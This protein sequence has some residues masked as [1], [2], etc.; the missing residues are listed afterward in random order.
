MT[1]GLLRP[2]WSRAR[3]TVGNKVAIHKSLASQAIDN[4]LPTR[5]PMCPVKVTGRKCRL[6]YCRLDFKRRDILVKHIARQKSSVKLQVS[7]AESMTFT[8]RVKDDREAFLDDSK[9]RKWFHEY[10][11]R[12]SDLPTSDWLHKKYIPMAAEKKT[13]DIKLAVKNKP[14]AILCDE[15]T[16]KEE[17]YFD[18]GCPKQRE[19]INYLMSDGDTGVLS[20][21]GGLGGGELQAGAGQDKTTT[22][23]SR[24]D[25]GMT[26]DSVDLAALQWRLLGKERTTGHRDNDS[27]TQEEPQQ[28]AKVDQG[29]SSTSSNNFQQGAT[30]GQL[31]EKTQCSKKP[32]FNMLRKTESLAPTAENRDTG[33]IIVCYAKK[34]RRGGLEKS[35]HL[36]ESCRKIFLSVT[37]MVIGYGKN[38]AWVMGE[39]VPF[40]KILD[41]KPTIISVPTR[42]ETIIQINTINDSVGIIPKQEITEGLCE[43]YNDIF[44]LPRD[45]LTF[46]QLNTKVPTEPNCAPIAVKPYH[47]PETHKEEINRQVEQ[48][49]KDDIIVS[50]RSPWNAPILVLPKKLDAMGQQNWKIVLDLRNLNQV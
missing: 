28:A 45:K 43:E 47:I 23:R 21:E 24:G 12:G 39:F 26:D 42:Y 27:G 14:I 48:M 9:L 44:Q 6:E 10:V 2:L 22:A 19:A 11:K 38:G 16:D 25:S 34:R 37:R 33:I 50:S 41:R 35:D 8:K 20:M 40:H 1:R 36:P 46:T 5:K 15:T 4:F 32:V 31:Q 29:G 17:G 13:E 18:I 7:I 49:L 3:G 30:L